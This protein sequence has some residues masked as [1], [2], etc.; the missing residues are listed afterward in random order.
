[1]AYP[2]PQQDAA[3]VNS[4][5]VHRVLSGFELRTI[6]LNMDQARDELLESNVKGKNPFKDKRV[7]QATYQAIDIE[8]IRNRIMGGTSHI[9]GTM[10]APG[11]NGYDA[12]LD[13]RLPFD[14]EAAKKFLAEAGYPPSQHGPARNSS[15]ERRHMVDRHAYPCGRHDDASPI[16][17]PA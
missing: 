8:A 12:K 14:P 17:Q 16:R 11:I 7:R 9:A 3:R 13:T 10:V 4:T 5:G 2:I 15:P 1:M 6:F